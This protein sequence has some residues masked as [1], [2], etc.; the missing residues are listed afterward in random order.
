MSQ[1]KPVGTMPEQY[2][3]GG[4]FHFNDPE[5]VS[6][7]RTAI[8]DMA[9]QF[10]QNLISGGEE[11]SIVNVSLP[12]Y[13]FESRSYLERITDNWCYLPH[14]MKKA[15]EAKDPVE[16][17]KCVVSLLV[18]GLH[19]TC[20]Q[21]KP[22]NPILGETYEATY[23]D[24][25][26]I[27]M[28]QSSHHPPVS[29]FE[30]IG[31]DNSW[32]VYGFGEWSAGFRANSVKGR[33]SGPMIAA[34][35]D[36]TKISF[37][38]P[39]TIIS[40]LIFG[41]RVMEYVEIVK[42]RDPKNNLALDLQFA[43]PAPPTSGF[44]GWLNSKKPPS[45]YIT[46][47]LYQ[48]SSENNEPKEGDKVVAEVSGSWLGCVKFNNEVHWDWTDEKNG[49]IKKY[50]PIPHKD[51]LPSDS[52]YRGDLIYLCKNETNLSQDWKGKLE[53]KQ[54]KEE[55]SRKE[56]AKNKNQINPTPTTTGTTTGT[57]TEKK[58]WW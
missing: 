13:L 36:G 51:P 15:A 34:F 21:L 8:W 38:L 56:V 4:G 32:H 45:D 50:A 53:V 39:W 3:S 31:P 48:T 12:V 23:E 22:F 1:D 6:K 2:Q 37:E 5:I 42:F 25:S 35:P 11:R 18:G 47:N 26:E 17:F 30:V 41:E 24:G 9:K 10:G 27:Y 57:T 33:Q 55:R 40:G 7:Q 28:E 49:L 19:N 14:Y 44:F 58:G 16:R 20:K 54:R 43:P 52:R 46:G 29:N